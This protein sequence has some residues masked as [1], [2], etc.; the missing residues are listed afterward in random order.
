[1]YEVPVQVEFELQRPK[2]SASSTT[3]MGGVT[4]TDE[5]SRPQETE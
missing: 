1:M 5:E 2:H 4:A 3:S